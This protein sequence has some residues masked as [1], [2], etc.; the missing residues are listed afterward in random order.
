MARLLRPVTK[1]ICSI[2]AA[3][4][5]ST[6]YWL[7]GLSTTGNIS[8]GIA[9]VAGRNRVPMPATGKTALRTLFACILDPQTIPSR[10][11]GPERAISGAAV[12][13]PACQQ[14]LSDLHS[15]LIERVDVPYHALHERAVLVQ[16]QQGTDGSRIEPRQPDQVPR[17]VAGRGRVRRSWAGA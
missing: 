4:A 15:P 7:R 12:L 3:A 14:L 9:L 11:S 2:P 16:R 10:T 5:S 1:I 8:L 17:P 6:A 13:H